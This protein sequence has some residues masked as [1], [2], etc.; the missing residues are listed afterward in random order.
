MTDGGT[1]TSYEESP[2][3]P[4]PDEL[5]QFFW[6]GVA[7]HELLIL[8]CDRCGHYIHEPLPHCR[9]C[10]SRDLTPTKVSGR[11]RLDTFTIIMQPSHPYF[12]ARVPYN[13]AVV[14]LEEQAGL[15]MVTNVVDCAEA[16]LRVGMA[17]EVTFRAVAPGVTLPQFRPA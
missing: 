14:E 5:T 2:P 15:K 12:L 9:F 7:R 6:D 4:V 1:V 13:L 10:L 16:D 17:L 3:V 11:A 8:R